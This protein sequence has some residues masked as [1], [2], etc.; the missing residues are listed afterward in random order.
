MKRKRLRDSGGGREKRDVWSG[1]AWRP[2]DCTTANLGDFEDA[3]FLGLEEI[4]GNAYKLTR[5]EGS[6]RVESR[7]ANPRS[8]AEDDFGEDNDNEAERNEGMLT[9]PGADEKKKKKKEQK[10]KE[11][12]KEKRKN[13]RKDENQSAPAPLTVSPHRVEDLYWGTVKLHGLLVK[14]LQ[15]LNF[16]VPTPIQ[17]A[18]IPMTL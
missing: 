16:H 1:L 12:K 7:G 2:I 8:G 18:A 13:G 4:D 9:S 14:S 6:Y 3:V 11:K 10:E 17:T 5:G 15:K